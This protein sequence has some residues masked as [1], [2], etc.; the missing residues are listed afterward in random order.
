MGKDW[1]FKNIIGN[2]K[3]IMSKLFYGLCDLANSTYTMIGIMFLMSTYFLNQ[4][5]NNAQIGG[6]YWQWIVGFCGIVIIISRLFIGAQINKKLKRK[7]NFVKFFYLLSI[8]TTYPLWF[9][10]PFA[11][12]ILFIL[13][14]F[15]ILSEIISF[16]LNI[17]NFEFKRIVP[18]IVAF[19]FFIFSLQM[20][21]YLKKKIS[22]KKNISAIPIF[23]NFFE[24]IWKNKSIPVYKFFLVGM[25]YSNVLIVLIAGSF[26]YSFEVFNFNLSDL[27]KLV[28]VGNIIALIGVLIGRYLNNNFSSKIIILFCITVLICAVVYGSFTVQTK[29]EFFNNLMIISFFIGSIQSN[30]Q[31][32]IAKLLSQVDLGKDFGL[33]SSFS[34]RTNVL[35]GS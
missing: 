3:I 11:N 19:F 24:I 1:C 28:I 13:I 30:S 33:F 2:G 6:A 7:I 17:N 12:Y 29:S 9:A 18:L 15:F 27:L 10:K 21:S 32:V 34:R 14:I 5:F 23:K 16:C 25:I 22:Y 4:I 35:D 20:I 26:I 8:L 31:L